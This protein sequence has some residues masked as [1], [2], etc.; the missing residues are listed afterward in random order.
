[1]SNEGY[2]WVLVSPNIEHKATEIHG[3][4]DKFIGKRNMTIVSPWT[5][6]ETVKKYCAE[7]ENTVYV[8]AKNPS[9]GAWLINY[10]IAVTST[11]PIAEG[12]RVD[13]FMKMITQNKKDC[14]VLVLHEGA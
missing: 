4:L 1:M 9:E 11:L 5:E 10:G 12:K 3:I 8:V 6:S 7:R 14:I 13:I 2:V